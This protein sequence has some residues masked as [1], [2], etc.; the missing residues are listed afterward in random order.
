MWVE[1]R[2]L[3]GHSF[4]GVG[5]ED[6]P[7][8]PQLRV[9]YFHP[10]ISDLTVNPYQP[11]LDTIFTINGRVYN[12]GN[13]MGVTNVGLWTWQSSG[14]GGRYI[15]INETNIS[16]L[17]QQ[18]ALFTFNVEAWSAGD[19]QLY[20]VL[21]NNPNNLTSVP[22]GLVREQTTGEAFLSSINTPMAFGFLILII[23]VMVMAIA[24]SKRVEE[25]WDEDDEE[26]IEET[27]PPPPWGLDNWPEWA[28]PPPEVITSTPS[29]YE[30]E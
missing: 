3:A 6:D 18:H 23:S 22:V 15:T 8:M 29:L 20:I 24:I 27:P 17:P 11:T 2:D 26:E 14:D 12:E 10:I 25:D 7:R 13:D 28:G 1:G 9:I 30:E 21:N 4:V 19:L 16:L 5:S